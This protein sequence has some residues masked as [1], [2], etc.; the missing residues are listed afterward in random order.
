MGLGSLILVV[1]AALLGSYTPVVPLVPAH[2]RRPPAAT[3]PSTRC[4]TG[5]WGRGCRCSTGATP[6]WRGP[7]WSGWRFTDFYIW[8]GRVRHLV[9]PAVLLEEA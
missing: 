4:A 8:H 1:N 5:L 7:H 9:R 6:S 2:H 3:S